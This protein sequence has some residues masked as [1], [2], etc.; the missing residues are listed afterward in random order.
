MADEQQEQ[1]PEAPYDPQIAPYMDTE[2]GE[3]TQVGPDG[4]RHPISELTGEERSATRQV[5]AG[6]AKRGEATGD[7]A[8][9]T[10]DAGE[11]DKPDPSKTKAPASKAAAAG[12]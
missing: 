4:K 5:E 9:A 12:A 2:S 6:D 8:G 10:S 7:K 11:G 1:N 3:V